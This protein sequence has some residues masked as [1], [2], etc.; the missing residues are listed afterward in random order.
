MKR[1][2]TKYSEIRTKA[3][4]ISANLIREIK[5]DQTR[6][7]RTGDLLPPGSLHSAE[8]SRRLSWTLDPRFGPKFF[9]RA[10]LEESPYSHRA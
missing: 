10:A 8:V 3:K 2:G 7:S 4:E 9:T 5:A 6:F 1:T